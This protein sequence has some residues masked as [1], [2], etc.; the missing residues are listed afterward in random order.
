[1]ELKQ[2]SKYWGLVSYLVC[3]LLLILPI[4]YSYSVPSENSDGIW[5][6]QTVYNTFV[7]TIGVGSWI[8]LWI[9]LPKIKNKIL[10]KIGSLV[11]ILLYALTVLII[12]YGLINV[13]QDFQFSIGSELI[14][15]ACPLILIDAYGLWNKGEE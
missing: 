5:L 9:I 3:G 7:Y 12:A 11:M 4:S 2:W 15:L 14:L 10:K 6:K 1:M 8:L 13:T